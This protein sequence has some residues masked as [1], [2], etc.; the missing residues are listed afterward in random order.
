MALADMHSEPESEILFTPPETIIEE[1]PFVFENEMSAETQ[2]QPEI[3]ELPEI[4]GNK[5]EPSE[6]KP[7]P[8]TRRRITTAGGVAKS[9]K[10]PSRRPRTIKGKNS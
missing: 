5:A 4:D 1:V 10:S 8:R 7:K 9:G 6:Q 3:E 2:A